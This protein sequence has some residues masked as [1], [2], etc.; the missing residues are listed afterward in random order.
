MISEVNLSAF[1]K[2]LFDEDSSSVIGTVFC[3]D[4]WGE[5]SHVCLRSV[6]PFH[7]GLFCG[8]V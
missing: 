2:R 3:S 6:K 4:A 7:Y 1:I 8:I 5:I